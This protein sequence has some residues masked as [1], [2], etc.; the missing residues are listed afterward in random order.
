MSQRA[1]ELPVSP[2][3]SGPIID[4]NLMVYLEPG[5]PINVMPKECFKDEENLRIWPSLGAVEYLFKDNNSSMSQSTN[6]ETVIGLM[7]RHDV[8]KGQVFILADTPRDVIERMAAE[9]R[10]FATFEIYP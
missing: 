5:G 1:P 9:P 8:A 10:L 7:D 2:G 4:T 3:F 6:L